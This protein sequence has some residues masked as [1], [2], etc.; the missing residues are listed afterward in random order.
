M[1]PSPRSALTC[2]TLRRPGPACARATVPASPAVAQNNPRPGRL[3]R[4]ARQ[5]RLFAG[6]ISPYSRTPWRQ[7][8]HHRRRR[9]HVDCHLAHVAR[10]APSG[11][12]WA[13]PTLVAPRRK[14][15]LTD[16]SAA[17]SSSALMS[18]LQQLERVCFILGVNDDVFRTRRCAR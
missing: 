17:F 13:P 2:R 18:R 4:P 10:L 12:T 14:K 9:I 3:A 16:P 6:A 15:P 8:G 11:K 1:S 7:E 5:G